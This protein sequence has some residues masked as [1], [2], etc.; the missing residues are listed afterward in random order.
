MLMLQNI[1]DQMTDFYDSIEEE[2]ATFFDNNF[3]WEYFHFKFLIYYLVRYRI[4]SH[5]DFIV[6][7]YRVAYRLYLEKLIMKQDFVAC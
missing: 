5:R 1:Y 4:V 7:H 3:D 2:Y 6:Y